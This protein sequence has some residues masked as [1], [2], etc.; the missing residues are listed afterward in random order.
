MPNIFFSSLVFW[1]AL[2]SFCCCFAFVCE[3]KRKSA[4]SSQVLWFAAKPVSFID[5]TGEKKKSL[6]VHSYPHDVACPDIDGHTRRKKIDHETI[7]TKVFSHINEAMQRQFPDNIVQS[8]FVW[9]ST[10]N[11]IRL[12]TLQTESVVCNFSQSCW[13]QLKVI[14]LGLCR[15]VKVTVSSEPHS[16]LHAEVTLVSAAQME[17]THF[18]PLYSFFSTFY[19]QAFTHA[20]YTTLYK[21]WKSYWG[22][23]LLGVQKANVFTAP[24]MRLLQ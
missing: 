10:A 7:E 5:Q 6:L 23:P 24:K 17:Q 12:E 16:R 3:A 2:A 9:F 11:Y 8:M 20:L 13:S 14:E 21:N 22:G 1:L 4:G 15:S 19:H 18:A